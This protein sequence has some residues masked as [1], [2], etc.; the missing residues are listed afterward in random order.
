MPIQRFF[1]SRGRNLNDEQ[2]VEMAKLALTLEVT[3]EH[4]V[5]IE[6]A[7]ISRELYLLQCLPITTQR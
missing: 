5:D 1:Q 7:Y 6:C 3:L 4:P 2:V